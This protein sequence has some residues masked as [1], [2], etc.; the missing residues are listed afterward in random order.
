MIKVAWMYPDTL[1][2]HGERGTVMALARCAEDLGVGSATDKI[3]MGTADFDPMDYD[4][5]FYGPGEL[6]S[7]PDVI[8]EISGYRDDLIRFIE[9]GRVLIVTGSSVAMF[10]NSIR[11]LEGTAGRG[12]EMVRGL[13]IIPVMSTERE[14]VFG[15]DE[16][17]RA[18]YG[19]R[20]ME[21]IGNQIQMTDLEM[22]GNISFFGDVIYGHGNNGRDGKE[23]FL[24]KNSIFTNM[25]GPLL[26]GNPWLTTEIIRNASAAS[27]IELTQTDPEYDMEHRSLELKKEFIMNKSHTV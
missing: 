9:S 7:F 6:P 19:G 22:C 11:M 21:L 26:A 23:G 13:G 10:G 15:D 17:V 8:D 1:Y 3:D 2:L 25:T 5:I 27:G 4:V 24:F 16:Y 12:S 20:Q 18:V 14:Y